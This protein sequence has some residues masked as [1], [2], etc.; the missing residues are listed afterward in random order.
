MDGQTHNLAAPRSS[1]GDIALV[2]E[3]EPI[4]AAMVEAMLG[5]LGY[6]N[7]RRAETMDEA[8]QQLDR[9]RPAIVVLDACL[10]GVPAESVA[11]RLRDDDIPFVVSTGF[12]PGE[13]PLAFQQAI[14]L[15]KPYAYDALAGAIEKAVFERGGPAS[16]LGQGKGAEAS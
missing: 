15:R 7:I 10:R 4:V 6:T 5:E 3:D 2:V 8:F 13:L 14:C 9:T 16:L 12:I 1:A 11:A